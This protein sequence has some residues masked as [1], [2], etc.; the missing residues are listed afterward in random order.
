MARG[1]RWRRIFRNPRRIVG[2][3]VL[4]TI[5]RASGKTLSV[6]ATTFWGDSMRLVAPEAVSM[7]IHR[8]GC[9]DEGMT[10]FLLEFLRPGM[11][12]YDVGAHFGY[13]T[14]LAARIVGESGTVHA[15]EPT[16]ATF[17]ILAENVSGKANVVPN[18][19]A[20]DSR[21][22]SV[23]VNDYGLRF[24]AFNS[25]FDPRLSRPAS[26]TF[27]RAQ[28]PIAAVA[29]DDY[30]AGGRAPDFVKIDAEGCEHRVLSGMAR[31]IEAHRPVVA[32]EVGD[33]GIEGTTPSRDVVRA[34]LDMGYGVHEHR[35][36][37]IVPHDVKEEY[38]DGNLLFLPA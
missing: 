10:R 4:E 25:L 2:S 5:L 16:P 28:V 31:I 32:V 38:E 23:I 21:T 1:S 6:E 26:A 27:G 9:F 22:G 34:L 15:F 17:S 8:Y 14:V 19:L 7:T 35:E 24:S 12:F 13:F 37:R 33:W 3:K 20:V 36:G 30:A 18:N 29:L 11:T